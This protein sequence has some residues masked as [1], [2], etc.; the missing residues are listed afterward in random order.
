M[1][2]DPCQP[3]GVRFARTG[4]A[5]APHNNAFT[6]I[7]L[8]VVIAIIAI[9]AAMLL[10]ALSKAKEK[11]KAIS[12]LNNARQLGMATMLYVLDYRD[13]FP[14]G[15]SVRSG[16]P[17]TWVDPTAWHIALLNYL[18]GDT[19][20]GPAVFACPSERPTDTFPMANGVMFQ[21]SY[22]ANEHV[23]RSVGGAANGP[24]RTT[25]VRSPAQTLTVF[26]KPYESWRF[27]MDAK[28]LAA[29]RLG[30][31]ST[32]NSLGYLTAGMSRH[33]GNGMGFAADGHSTRLDMPDYAAG[34]MPPSTLGNIGD[35][36]S[37]R[38]YWPT[39]SNVELYLREKNTTLGF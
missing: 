28:E 18:G 5:R 25:Q 29:V 39:P 12:C 13:A 20:R 22:R 19:N 4:R 11:A 9:L 27:S 23:F 6:L 1:K 38:G 16:M 32:G 17:A 3:N 30:W 36:R 14:Y 33:S 8:L 24:L 15:V 2:Q 7:E 21:A 37:D 34:A 26:E 35:T 31:N 10:P